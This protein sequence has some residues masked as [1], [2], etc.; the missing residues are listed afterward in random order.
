[1]KRRVFG[2]RFGRAVAALAIV[3]GLLGLRTLEA[4]ETVLPPQGFLTV[5]VPANSVVAMAV[6]FRGEPVYAGTAESVS[7]NGIVVPGAG[8]GSYGPFSS[9]PHFVRVETG[10]AAGRVFPIDDNSSEEIFLRGSFAGSLAAGDKFGIFP[11]PTLAALFGGD[12][13]GLQADSDPKQADN[14]LLRGPEGWVTYYHDG[15]SWQREGGTGEPQNTTAVLPDEGFLLVRRAPAPLELRLGG[16][17]PTGTT[18]AEVSGGESRLLAN[19]LPVETTLEDLGLAAQPGWAASKNP[20]EADTVMLRGTAGWISYFFDGA[21]WRRDGG[22]PAE[23]H[24]VIRKG[25]AYFIVRRGALPV[26]ATQTP[27]YPGNLP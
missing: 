8:W 12:A 13:G 1:M 14:V 19:A 23:V 26:R 2:I 10:A 18:V 16:T 5:S 4:A 24:P 22:G 7:E 27:T 25:A 11:A 21:K 20:A 3:A 9:N 6:P 17:V 15:S